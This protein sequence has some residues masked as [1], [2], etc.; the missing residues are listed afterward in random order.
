MSASLGSIPLLGSNNAPGN[1]LFE[2]NNTQTANPPSTSIG[3]IVIG[4]QKG[5]IKPTTITN[6]DQFLSLYG[7][8]NPNWSLA[9][10]SALTFLK[11]SNNL[12]VRRVVNT[13]SLTAASYLFPYSGVSFPS[14]EGLQLAYTPYQ[15]LNY[16][17]GVPQFSII[18]NIPAFGSVASSTPVTVV[19][20]L[21]GGAPVTVTTTVGANINQYIANLNAALNPAGISAFSSNAIITGTT[22][23]PCIYFAGPTQSVFAITSVG[24][25]SSTYTPITPSY[26][27]DVFAII[28]QNPGAWP[29]NNIAWTITNVDLGTAQQLTLT[30]NRQLAI[31]DTVTF[32]SNVYLQGGTVNTAAYNL[33]ATVPYTTTNDATLTAFASAIQAAS[34]NGQTGFLTATAVLPDATGANGREIIITLQSKNLNGNYFATATNYL[35]AGNGPIDYTTANVGTVYNGTNTLSAII[36]Q[37]VRCAPSKNTFNLNVY[38]ASNPNVPL[39]TFTGS[40]GTT[41]NSATGATNNIEM[42]VNNDYTGSKYI[43]LVSTLPQ[44]VVVFPNLFD[45]ITKLNF[46]NG[47]ADGSLPTNV[48][49]ANA[50]NDFADTTNITVNMLIN[51]GYTSPTVQQAMDAVVQAR[52]DMSFA[53]LDMPSNVQSSTGAGEV[54]YRQ[55]LL[56]LSSN[57]SAIYSPDILI[58]DPYTGQNIYIPPSGYEASLQA[59]TDNNIGPQQIAAGPNYGVINSALGLRVIYSKPVRGIL[60]GAQVN[61]IK[62]LRSGGYAVYGAVTLATVP[63]LLSFIPVRR[64]F[65]YVEELILSILEG[66]D[67]DNI[68]PTLELNVTQTIQGY[69]ITFINNNAIQNGSVI[70][71]S[72]VNT[73]NYANNGQFNVRVIIYPFSPAQFVVLDAVLTNSSSVFTESVV[74]V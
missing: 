11:G 74:S 30:F 69:L 22:S 52:Q 29:N 15:D 73:Q 25:N 3:G 4:C 49:I 21:N 54:N 62:K 58:A 46:L 67:F 23:A 61:A 19:Y 56:N 50:W 8:P 45:N 31:G 55:N 16:S 57:R 17:G 7:T 32:N 1:Y 66:V 20:T 65:S 60:N 47:G 33:T 51:G 44:S 27:N 5:D 35:T 18:N 40:L 39:E 36:T 70:A 72:T 12:I 37:S 43:R 6:P 13:D 38:S 34:V 10:Y 26:S 59:I 64:I 71:D 2:Q 63:S 28:A 68:T 41:I 48:Q 24:Y 42:I 9:G 14:V 53:Y